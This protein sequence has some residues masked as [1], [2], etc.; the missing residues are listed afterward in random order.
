MEVLRA[1]LTSLAP[2]ITYNSCRSVAQLDGMRNTQETWL[3]SATEPR[4]FAG[5]SCDLPLL[6]ILRRAI[7][8]ETREFQL[9]SSS[10]SPGLP[11]F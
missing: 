3:T 5:A 11:L 9:L 1:P 6:L 7:I 8:R 10:D 2:S 4:S